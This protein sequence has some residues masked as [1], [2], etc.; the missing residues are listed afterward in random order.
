MDVPRCSAIQ[1]IS[2]RNSLGTRNV[3][4]FEGAIKVDYHSYPTGIYLAI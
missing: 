2:S 3:V 4:V 1:A